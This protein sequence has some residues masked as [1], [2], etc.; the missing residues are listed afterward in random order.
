MCLTQATTRGPDLQSPRGIKIHSSANFDA[1]LPCHDQVLEG[2]VFLG[3]AQHLGGEIVAAFTSAVSASAIAVVHGVIMTRP[4][5]ANTPLSRLPGA[6]LQELV[7]GV[8]SDLFRTCL[9]QVDDLASLK[10]YFKELV[11]AGACMGH[12]GL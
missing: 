6:S 2:Y 1:N 3:N 4:G 9:A 12:S 5:S 7:H 10:F 8:P 11:L